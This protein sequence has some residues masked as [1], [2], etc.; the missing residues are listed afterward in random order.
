NEDNTVYYVLR[1]DEVRVAKYIAY[2]GTNYTGVTVGGALAYVE[3][4]DDGEATGASI[5]EK[6]IIRNEDTMKAYFEGID[7]GAFQVFTEFGGDP[8]TVSSTTYGSLYK[9]GSEYW[10]S[11]DLGWSGNMEAIQEAAEENGTGY[12]LDEMVR[13]GD[14]RW[15]LTDAVTSATASDFKDYFGLIQQAVGRLKM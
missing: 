8:Q 11:G 3:S 4:G 14:N 6:S 12:G 10:N 5:L 13:R 2:D 9:R 7:D 1:G 15:A